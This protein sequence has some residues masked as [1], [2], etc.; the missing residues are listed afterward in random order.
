VAGIDS[1][2][3]SA[4]VNEYYCYGKVMRRNQASLHLKPEM[5]HAFYSFLSLFSLPPFLNLIPLR[6]GKRNTRTTE[7]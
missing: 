1:R 4:L 5:I 3:V 2:I 7:K 6:T